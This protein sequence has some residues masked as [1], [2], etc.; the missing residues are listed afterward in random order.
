MPDESGERALRVLARGDSERRV[1]EVWAVRGSLEVDLG[2]AEP[3]RLGCESPV[4]HGLE[5]LTELAAFVASGRVNLLSKTLGTAWPGR[6]SHL[7]YRWRGEYDAVVALGWKDSTLGVNRDGDQVRF[8]VLETDDQ[9]ELEDQSVTLERGLV[10]SLPGLLW[11]DLDA[12]LALVGIE[13]EARERTKWERLRP[14]FERSPV[15]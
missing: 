3:L 15:S 2:L 9:P 14:E 1:P 8:T 4:T 12:L 5:P 13:L 7:Y 11:Q 10:L 6:S